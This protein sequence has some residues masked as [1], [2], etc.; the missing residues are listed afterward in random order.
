MRTGVARTLLGGAI[1]CG[2]LGLAVGSAS[3]GP[4]LRPATPAPVE[5]ARD[6][7]GGLDSAGFRRIAAALRTKAARASARTQPP[8][9]RGTRVRVVVQPQPGRIRQ[10]QALLHDTTRP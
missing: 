2:A 5:V 9:T 3:S 6:A 8:A 7:A 1:V 10:A 4:R